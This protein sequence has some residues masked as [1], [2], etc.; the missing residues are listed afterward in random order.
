[1]NG[2]YEQTQTQQKCKAEAS[3][4]DDLTLAMAYGL[5]TAK[6]EEVPVQTTGP[7][8]KSKVAREK[9]QRPLV[10]QPPMQIDGGSKD[11]SWL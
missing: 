6:R 4:T 8:Q 2:T 5:R 9:A 1:V 10:F 7:I 3:S 11:H